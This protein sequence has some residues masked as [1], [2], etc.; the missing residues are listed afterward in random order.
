MQIDEMHGTPSA[1]SSF[2]IKPAAVH[3]RTGC[4]E[5]FAASTPI[6][7]TRAKQGSDVI[8][9]D[10]LPRHIICA[11]N[12]NACC[13]SDMLVPSIAVQGDRE[14]NSHAVEP[15]CLDMETVPALHT[16]TMPQR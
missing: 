12:H 1:P 10:L 13:L 2:V 8:D 4:T 7:T 6:L 15:L 14:H 3:Q 11:S 9:D 16:T 5:A